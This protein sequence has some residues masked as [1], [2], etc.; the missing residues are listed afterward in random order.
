[1]NVIQN[2]RYSAKSEIFIFIDEVLVNPVPD[3]LYNWIV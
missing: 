1:M 2:D 3:E